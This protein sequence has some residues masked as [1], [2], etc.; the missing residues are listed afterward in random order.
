LAVPTPAQAADPDYIRSLEW[1]ITALALPDV[2]KK[3]TGQGITVAV[4]DSGVDA[5]HPDL[6]G[7]VT[8]GPDGSNVDIDGRGTGLAGFVAGKGH[9]T[10]AG[11]LGVAPGAKILPISFA[12]A[13]GE[14]GDAE[15]LASGIELATSRG[16]NIICIGR[17]STP[18][19]RLEF[20]IEVAADRGALVVAV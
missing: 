18:N 20:A 7:Q 2:H 6:A 11:V 14:V 9:A 16:A 13:P 10:D 15:H 3:S 8:Q 19:E 12:P 5:Q 1:Q 17:S 4:V